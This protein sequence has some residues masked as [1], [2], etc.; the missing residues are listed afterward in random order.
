MK[1]V[2]IKTLSDNYTWVIHSDDPTVREAWI[3]DAGASRPIID[4]FQHN[5]YR[6][7]GILL[8]HHHYDHTDGIAGLLDAL[9]EVPIVSNPRGPY[10]HVTAPIEAGESITL[11]GE[12]FNVLAIPGHT[13][14]HYA[15]YHPKAVFC[16]DVLF[17]GGC[18]KTWTQD[19]KCMAESLLKLRA[20][21]ENCQIYCGH[22]YTYANLNF[23]KI[24]EPDNDAITAR[25][26]DVK[27]KTQLGEA[28]VPAPLWLEKQTNPFLRFDL[29]P[30][31]STLLTKEG[32]ED[33]DASR[34][35]TLRSWKDALD[36]TGVLEQGLFDD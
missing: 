2:G 7:A 34:Y 9:G 22:E 10:R 19:P 5:Q 36:S 28:C 3:V 8:T 26:K 21:D 18:G 25:L 14:E 12:T 23:A 29:E 33:T 32:C 15:F 35:S 4:Y 16:G 13:H 11:F 31:K 20:L 24:V 1:I 17:T 6:L 27:H 30:L